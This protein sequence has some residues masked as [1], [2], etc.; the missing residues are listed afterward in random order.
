LQ[1]CV[2]VVDFCLVNI[3]FGFAL[4]NHLQIVFLDPAVLGQDHFDLFS[5]KNADKHLATVFVGGHSFLYMLEKVGI[6]SKAISLLD[7]NGSAGRIDF[8]V[9]WFDTGL[10]T[11]E[12]C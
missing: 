10:E 12:I 8:R 3:A 11:T 7:D 5:G 2:D 6:I 4:V 9:N 1:G